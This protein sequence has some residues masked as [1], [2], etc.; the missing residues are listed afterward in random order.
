MTTHIPINLY[1]NVI[2]M[3]DGVGKLHFNVTYKKGQYIKAEYVL[4]ERQ[5]DTNIFSVKGDGFYNTVI[6]HN[7]RRVSK[8]RKNDCIDYFKNN[9]EQIIKDCEQW[10]K[11]NR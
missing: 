8:K 10:H 6:E 5:G 4:Y 2:D 1:T 9:C 3:F 11:E 7:M